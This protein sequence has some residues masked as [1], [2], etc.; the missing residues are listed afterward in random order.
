VTERYAAPELVAKVAG[1]AI[2]TRDLIDRGAALV[3]LVRSPH[4]HALITAIDT[5]NAL[6][7][8]GVLGV[9]TGAA[10]EP[11]RLGHI[12]ADQPVLAAGRVRHVGEPVVAVCAE[13]REALA[14][15]VAAVTVSYRPLAHALAVHDALA[16]GVA[17]HDGCPTNIAV[18]RRVEHGDWP[19]VSGRVAVWAEGTFIVGPQHHA[20]MEPH[21]ALARYQ[22]GRIVLHAPVHNPHALVHEYAPHTTRWEETFAVRT[23]VIGG[24]FGAHYE[25]PIHLICSEFAR[26]LRRD[27]GI[28]LSR[29]EDLLAGNARMGM[30]LTVRL[31]ATADGRIIAKASDV[32]ADNGAYSL[33]G[34]SVAA[35][36][37]IRS[38]NLYR[39]E[40]VSTRVRTVYTNAV[41]SQCFRG[42]GTPQAV[43]AQE[44][45]V[46]E[47]AGKLG[48]DA[49]TLRR[50]SATR[51]GDVTIHG[52]RV[53]QAGL[54]ACLDAIDEATRDERAR[55]RTAG[56]WQRGLGIACAVHVVS[57]RAAALDE[58][59]A[60]VRLRARP[61]GGLSIASGEVEIGA[62]TVATL[63]RLV[64]DALGVDPARVSVVVG[65]TDATPPGLGSF[66]SRTSF[67]AGNA[68]LAAA[69]A[70]RDR[71]ASVAVTVGCVVDDEPGTVLTAAASQGRTGELDVTGEYVAAGV[72]DVDESLAGN[73]SP[74]YTFAAHA[75][76]VRVDTA[77]GAVT[78]ERY[79][80]A[81][82]AGTVLD[83]ASA[84][85][86][87]IGGVM[88]GLGYACLEEVVTDDAGRML[89]PGFLDYR[90]P[91]APDSFAVETVFV[92]S[93]EPAGPRGAKTIAEPPLIPVAAC[94]ANAVCDAAG[95]RVRR[96]PL[97]AERVLAAIPQRR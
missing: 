3:G 47:L 85:G 12:I 56:R 79:V 55:P 76:A 46:D 89:N 58:D 60:R 92:D 1:S 43:F 35:A 75:S 20:P 83:D 37:A 82:D 96:L 94:V 62:G 63:R 67:F 44:Q 69:A 93:F 74:T 29:R 21:A 90:I 9:L 80:A 33:H 2:Y 88:Q 24:S 71:L 78:V 53:A 10:F 52:W 28:V 19:A 18:E 5:A 51:S 68:A 4:P 65:D 84:R 26:R 30:T 13:T 61:D 97:T 70:M 45:L 38:D 7:L 49:I 14:A 50:R 42:F 54:L 66:A 23:P 40:A 39:L 31:G 73:V 17:I 81:H 87:V 15:A 8:P 57:N 25:H 34:P 77:T 27:V 64:C 48:I 91:T 6:A 36:A 32:L 11:F 95:A 16:L 72:S 41:P 59:Y 86:Q 22:P